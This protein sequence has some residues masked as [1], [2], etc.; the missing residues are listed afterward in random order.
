MKTEVK[1][2][3]NAEVEITVTLPNKKLETYREA[4]EKELCK[5]VE[6]DGF[7]KGNVP[8]EV[9]MKEISAMH[10]LNSM[11]EHAISDAY[12]EILQK[13]NIQAIGHPQITITKIAE[14]SDLEFRIVTA[15]LPTI[16]LGNYKKIAKEEN[17][18]D[19]AVDV[20]DKEV[21][22]AVLNVRKMRA[23]QE[24]M[25][26]MKEGDE[27]MSWNDINDEDLPELTDEWVTTLGAFEN[28]DAFTNKIK[29]NL[30]TEKE[31]KNN[32]KRRIAI[33]EAIIDSSL[34]EVPN[35]MVE[36]EIDKMIHEFEGNIAMTGTS[37]DDYLQS[38]NKT[39]EDYRKEW[40]DQA[41]K[42][43]QTQLILNEIAR[44][45]KIEPSDDVIEEEVKKIME[46]YKDQ[47]GIDE[48]NVRAYVAT[49]LTHQE[50]FNYLEKQK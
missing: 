23:Q 39:R 30:R 2:L 13:E 3:E 6:V 37:F 38:I 36:Y 9:A 43:A 7:R 19:Y 27:P 44:N 20:D 21:E 33:I 50:V 22:E 5:H 34:V 4:T 45:E 8:R 14:G 24:S 46:Q 17:T 32:E 10:I 47:K 28:I 41:Y 26:N 31:A 48:N 49:V 11:A 15:V 40:R 1:K 16:K 25:K 18:K 29:E 42:R 12:L 35:I